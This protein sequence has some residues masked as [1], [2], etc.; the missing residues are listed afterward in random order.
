MMVLLSAMR[1]DADAVPVTL[2]AYQHALNYNKTNIFLNAT[3]LEGRLKTLFTT[4]P[5]HSDW[6]EQLKRKY[7]KW[8][9]RRSGCELK[10]GYARDAERLLWNS[11]LTERA[12][13]FINTFRHY[14]IEDCHYCLETTTP[15]TVDS[16]GESE[17][18]D[19][20]S[21]WIRLANEGEAEDFVEELP[22]LGEQAISEIAGRHD[23]SK[24]NSMS[25]MLRREAVSL[26]NTFFTIIICMHV[27]CFHAKLSSVAAKVN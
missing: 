8:E 23:N 1:S 16:D 25:I 24:S 11:E 17:R 20:A 5:K 26:D 3:W 15:L 4:K 9:K 14:F 2:K 22:T 7:K 13:S 19:T 27:N 12:I 21:R 10:Y 18:E 6:P